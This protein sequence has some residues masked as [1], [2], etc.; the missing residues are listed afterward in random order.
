MIQ[1]S[2]DFAGEL[3]AIDSMPFPQKHDT[4]NERLTVVLMQI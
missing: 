1:N 4:Q 2:V 3:T